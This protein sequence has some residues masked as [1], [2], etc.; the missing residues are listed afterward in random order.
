M[1]FRVDYQRTI[2]IGQVPKWIT[3]TLHVVF[4]WVILFINHRLSGVTPIHCEGLPIE[5][6]SIASVWKVWVKCHWNLIRLGYKCLV[7]EFSLVLDL[8]AN[9]L[10]FFR[11]LYN[12]V[13]VETVLL[14][15]DV[16]CLKPDDY[17][18]ICK[19]CV[20]SCRIKQ[21]IEITVRKVWRI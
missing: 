21:L 9:Y 18:R 2:Q 5:F 20:N 3:R 13:I 10:L 14:P 17:H 4:C 8:T 11:V 12:K 1:I 6:E 16:N 15:L 7:K 19:I